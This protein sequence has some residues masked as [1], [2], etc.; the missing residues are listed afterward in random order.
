MNPH[1]SQSRFLA[2][3]HAWLLLLALV[4]ACG[5]NYSGGDSSGSN[6]AAGGGAGGGGQAANSEQF[7]A[8]SIAPSLNFCRNCHIPGGVA[9]TPEGERFKLS[10]LDANRKPPPAT[11]DYAKL[12]ASWIALG[13]GVD[14]NK[15]L[16]EATVPAEPHSGG[17][18]WPVGSVPYQNMKILL[19][20]WDKPADCAALLGNGGTPVA[21]LPL[22]GS[23]QARH[24]WDTFCE[25]DLANPAD[26]AADDAPLPTDPRTLIQPG[27]NTNK[28]V[29]YNAFWQD[30][31]ANAPEKEK[32]AKTCGEYRARRDRG[33]HFMLD[34][35]PTGASSAASHNNTWQK[36]GLSARPDN[37]DALYTLRYGLNE[38]PFHNPYPLPGEDP[39]VARDC[40]D[41]RK[42]VL[43]GCGRLPLGLRQGKDAS[44]NWTGQIGSAACLLCHGG[45][46]GEP[47]LIGFENLGSG[48]NN[49]DVIMG[50]RDGSP[51]IGTPVETLLPPFDIN[52]VFNI[53]VKQRGQNNAVGAFEF[54]NTLLDVDT[55]GINPNPL[56]TITTGGAQGVLDVSHPLAHTQD[57]PAWWNMGSRPRKFFDAGVSNDSTRII[58]AAG[59]GEID[60]LFTYDG[61]PY[62]TRIEE[63]DQDLEAYFLSLRSP[64][65]PF[66]AADGTPEINTALA[67]QGAVLFHSK[68]L[69]AQ[70]GNAS[71][72]RPLGG[73]GSCASCHGAYSP[74]YVNDP[75]YLETPALE[76]VAGHISPLDVIGTDTARSDMLTPT[77]RAGWDST[78][79]GYPE[80]TPGYV[81]PE[82]KD[83]LTE[84]LDDMSPLR[85]PGLC[86]WQKD[87]IGYQAPPLY[88]VWATAPYFHNGAVPTVEAVLD[89]SKRHTIWQRNLR[90][91]GPVTGFDQRLEAYDEQAMGW[92]HQAMT[93]QEMPGTQQINCN[94]SDDKGPSM[95]QLVQNF[96][97]STLS[98]AGL[99]TIPDPAPD[100]IDKR[101]VYDSR[102]LGN[103]NGGH[104]FTD[105]LTETERKAVI[106]YLKTL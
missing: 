34:E 10:P 90:S 83:P 88:G 54:L 25:G 43:G 33:R 78:Y 3:N 35:L 103:G 85:Q 26:N 52:Y 56:K 92:K 84:L 16:I 40:P 76:G 95:Q 105:V 46:I 53:G 70:E 5:G 57:T 39:K 28:A 49:Y 71:R 79:W 69:W 91:E 101:L 97:N 45:Q 2:A 18:P 36:W 37:F 27:A 80:G 4:T 7:F 22:L 98:W 96:L 63:W 66:K 75:A 73:N 47:T 100:S 15:L 20:C 11:D 72:A 68:D 8:Q 50:A 58:M 93:C 77:L 59:P 86:G 55:L 89:S 12:N 94:P 19:Q 51:F 102:I 48:N 41:G 67:E 24:V 42:N 38:A 81:A 31:H 106:E 62:R 104:E 1:A 30:C 64:Q 99:L 17:K 44:G 9:D 32:Q 23:K 21:E 65:W 14:S 6:T 82:D 29:Y 60:G 87:V 13:K 74:R 61:V